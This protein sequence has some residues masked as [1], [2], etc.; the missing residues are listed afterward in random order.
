[1]ILSRFYQSF[2]ESLLSFSFI[3]W[4]NSL[5]VHDKNS[6]SSIVNLCSKIIGEKQRD[7]ASFCDQQTIRKAASI[8]NISD[9]VLI[10]E[11]V[12]LQSGKRYAMPVCKTNR[13]LK[14]FVP[15]AIRLLN[16]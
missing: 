15:T 16:K 1:M 7:L 8:L 11:F 12:L 4:F 2:I 10:S 5:S 3:C 6:L 14:S 13:H 9:H